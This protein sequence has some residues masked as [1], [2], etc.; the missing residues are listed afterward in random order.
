MFDSFW[1]IFTAT[2]LI[3]ARREGFRVFI[4]L[5][6][7]FFLSLCSLLTQHRASLGSG[8]AGQRRKLKLLFFVFHFCLIP[9]IF[10]KGLPDQSWLR[11]RRSLDREQTPV[12][13][14]ARIEDVLVGGWCAS[15][16]V[17]LEFRREK[18]RVVFAPRGCC[19]LAGDSEMRTVSEADH[20]SAPQR[21]STC[22]R[23]AEALNSRQLSR[24][25]LLL[26]LFNEV[27]RC[28]CVF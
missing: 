24:D 17:A 13:E 18:L 12:S 28:I 21:T 27:C 4:F 10:W 8:F 19:V 2:R 3:T 7:Y 25:L 5:F 16:S 15:G 9:P 22:G 14:E 11:S 26:D 1:W 23:E 20:L 6:F